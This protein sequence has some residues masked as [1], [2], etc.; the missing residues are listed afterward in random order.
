MVCSNLIDLNDDCL[1]HIVSFLQLS[2]LLNFERTCNRTQEIT[3][4]LYKKLSHFKFWVRSDL[5]Q[6]DKVL[7]SVGQFVQILDST[8]VY[9]DRDTRR[10]IY[11]NIAHHCPYVHTIKLSSIG[12][13]DR[14]TVEE[15]EPLSRCKS[16]K[17]I[18]FQTY[19]ES[20]EILKNYEKLKYLELVFE[21]SKYLMH[22][23]PSDDFNF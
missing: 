11:E 5:E 10:N 6:P 19:D 14:E 7:S 3:R 17:S 15:L 2:D 13:P 20:Q 18:V 9:F 8:V 12:F 23:W 1:L 16:L 21:S 4:N 22:P